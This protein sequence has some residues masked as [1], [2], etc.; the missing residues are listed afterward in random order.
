VAGFVRDGDDDDVVQAPVWSDWRAAQ[1]ELVN[2][3]W[4]CWP[5]SAVAGDG[6]FR[7]RSLARASRRGGV[8]FSADVLVCCWLQLDRLIVVVRGCLSLSG[9]RTTLQRQ[10]NGGGG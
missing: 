6:V 2:D 7:A 8:L 3:F 5:G 1:V 9:N 4:L 10:R